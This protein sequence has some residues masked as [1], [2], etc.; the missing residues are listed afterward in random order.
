MPRNT[1]VPLLLG[2]L[3]FGFGF[4]MIWHMFWLSILSALAIVATVIIRATA[5]EHEYTVTPAKLRQ[6]EAKELAA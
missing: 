6:L 3:A 5:D 2:A 4:G 1:P